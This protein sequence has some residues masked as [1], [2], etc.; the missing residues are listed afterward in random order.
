M[1]LPDYDLLFTTIEELVL[2]HSPSGV[3]G[4][5]DRLLIK[6]FADYLLRKVGTCF[7]SVCPLS[8][9]FR[10]IWIRPKRESLGFVP[11][12]PFRG[13]SLG[14]GNSNRGLQ[15]LSGAAN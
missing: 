1:C 15:A 8:P 5:I 12:I 10:Q 4:E 13:L 6:R 9:N 2:H 11:N 7:S 14:K 3:E